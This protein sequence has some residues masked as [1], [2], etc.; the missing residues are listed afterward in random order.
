MSYQFQSLAEGEV[1]SVDES[2]PKVIGH[3][4]FKVGEFADALKQKLLQ[5]GIR[6]LADWFSAD[7]V[8]CEV[9]KFGASG[10]QRGWVRVNL[11]FRQGQA[12]VSLE[13][14]PTQT[15]NFSQ[16]QEKAA[17]GNLASSSADRKERSSQVEE[18]FS[19]L[20]EV[21]NASSPSSDQSEVLE[22]EQNDLGLA[23]LFESYSSQPSCSDERDRS[24]DED[25]DWDLAEISRH[26][27][28]ELKLVEA[29]ETNPSMDSESTSS[30]EQL[31]ETVWQDLFQA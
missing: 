24:D 18:E 13:F 15:G 11:E 26:I 6:E 3:C 8:A 17:I 27:D 16:A 28:E 2:Q 4:T 12:S 14:S 10:W 23:E 25:K 9:L 20:V 21:L 5:S 1:L 19:A 22:A 29:S 31:L 7:G 30:R